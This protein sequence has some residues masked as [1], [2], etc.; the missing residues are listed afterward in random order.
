MSASEEIV[1]LS[2]R[3]DSL[4][5]ECRRLDA[6]KRLRDRAGLLM[7]AAIVV[8]TVVGARAGFGDDG[9]VSAK[10]FVLLNERGEPRGGLGVLPDGTATLALLG[11]DGKWR[12]A[13]GVAEKGEASITVLDR[14]QNPRVGIETLDDGSA[15]ISHF[16]N[17][18]KH[19]SIWGTRPDGTRFLSFLD[20]ARKQRASIVVAEDGHPNLSLLDSSGSDRL[21][22]KIDNTDDLAS[23]TV[24]AKDGKAD[25]V[26]CAGKA[27]GF[28]V[29][30][31][32]GLERVQ[33]GWEPDAENERAVLSLSGSKSSG[34]V[35][36]GALP[37]GSALLRF[38][39]NKEHVRL[40]AG[41]P[42][43]GT[44]SISLLDDSGRVISRMPVP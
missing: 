26:I 29:N 2:A 20:A 9:V 38:S 4:E 19:A 13:I 3:I 44:P 36:M 16:A 28:A 5:R 42:A 12:L 25:G 30:G 24:Y 14:Y 31:S 41:N 37:K 43:D 7:A 34:H 8:V 18:R 27:V 1:L 40:Q 32:D 21:Q 6:A 39:D 10:K 33:L 15:A 17:D 22:F 23:V 35:V 11:N